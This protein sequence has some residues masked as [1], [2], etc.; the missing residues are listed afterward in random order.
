MSTIPRNLTVKNRNK[1][2]QQIPKSHPHRKKF[3]ESITC[4]QEQIW[5]D[6]APIIVSHWTVCLYIWKRWY[7]NAAFQLCNVK[8]EVTGLFHSEVT[9]CK[10]LQLRD[11][12]MLQTSLSH[13]LQP[14]LQ[15]DAL[16]FL[17]L[18][19]FVTQLQQVKPGH[20]LLSHPC[21]V[22]SLSCHIPLL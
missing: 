19:L 14:D 13:S 8:C 12:H 1:K 2:T 21:C 3:L 5:S 20:Q 18:W 16:G 15:R 10:F 11:I 4:L 17:Q 9:S 6:S 7:R 22:T